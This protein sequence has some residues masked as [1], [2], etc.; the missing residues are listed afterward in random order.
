MVVAV[1]SPPSFFL[2]CVSPTPQKNPRDQ[3]SFVCF[4]IIPL[5]WNGDQRARVLFPPPL[6]ATACWTNKRA[7]DW[8]APPPRV[9]TPQLLASGLR[10]ASSTRYYCILL[11]GQPTDR[12]PVGR[13]AASR[14]CPSTRLHGKET[15]SQE[16]QQ[17]AAASA[18]SPA[19][20]LLR[21]KRGNGVIVIL[22]LLQEERPGRSGR[23]AQGMQWPQNQC[24][25]WTTAEEPERQQMP[26]PRSRRGRKGGGARRPHRSPVGRALCFGQRRRDRLPRG[27]S[28]TAPPARSP[29]TY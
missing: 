17:Q 22:H 23:I 12:L 18:A 8:E 1:P 11:L 16:Q 15:E 27:Q 19:L 6:I 10:T 9:L 26:Q 13:Q 2:V 21:H 7:S 25:G 28:S 3:Q 24:H 20:L 5:E 4:A 29:P 14:G